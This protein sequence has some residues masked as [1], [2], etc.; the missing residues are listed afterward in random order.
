MDGRATSIASAA[1]WRARRGHRQTHQANSA[2]TTTAAVR[3]SR[4]AAI[5]STTVA[6]THQGP[7]LADQPSRRF[8]RPVTLLPLLEG[9]QL[10]VLALATERRAQADNTNRRERSL[11]PMQPNRMSG[12]A[13][14]WLPLGSW[15]GRRI[16]A[17]A[18]GFSLTLCNDAPVSELPCSLRRRRRGP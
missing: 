10:Q 6:T 4:T 17:Q 14:T 11:W 2:A 16:A 8:A 1:M 12:E 18:F 5:P 7:C 9:T 13:T 15:L 3:G